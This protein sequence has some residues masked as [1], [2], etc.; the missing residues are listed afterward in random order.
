MRTVREIEAYVLATK[1]WVFRYRYDGAV[2]EAVRAL[3]RGGWAGG[4]EEEGEGE[5]NDERGG[6]GEE[7]E[8]GSEQVNAHHSDGDPT[9]T[10]PINL[11]NLTVLIPPPSSPED[12]MCGDEDP[13][14]PFSALFPI[15]LNT[16]CALL[17][18]QLNRDMRDLAGLVGPDCRVKML[19]YMGY[20]EE[21][22]RTL[23][24]EEGMGVFWE[25]V[26]EAWRGKGRVGVRGVMA[27]WEEVEILGGNGEGRDVKEKEKGE[28]I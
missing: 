24:G 21:M 19:V 17:R 14:Y 20:E 25:G 2:V 5:D 8:G 4:Q 16:K 13:E 12:D 27:G 6:N 23:G 22:R 9:P 15:P 10:P 28:L 1:K 7:R 18:A 3:G 26:V 11:T